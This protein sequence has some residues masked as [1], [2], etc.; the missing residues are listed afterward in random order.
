[1]KAGLVALVLSALAVACGPSA[2]PPRPA[3]AGPPPTFN[4]DVAPILYEHCAPCHRPGQGAPFVLLD[5]QDVKARADKIARATRVREMPPWLPDPIE[6][7]FVGERRLRPDQIDTIQRWFASG[8]AE[9]APA[10][11]PRRPSW[12]EGWQS[13]QPD[14]VLTPAKA[15]ILQPQQD[16]V[17][18]NLVIPVA[19]PEDRFVRAVEFSPGGAPVHHAV[20]HLDRTSASRRR[21]GSDGHPGFEGMGAP[22]R[23]SRRATSSAGRRAA[24][25]LSRRRAC[26]GCSSAARTWCSSCT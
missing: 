9:G 15:Y 19:L 16:D 25:R 23:R 8:A 18:R 17:Y 26:R 14:L 24:D 20:V 10:D 11:L 5:Y 7:G 21:D 13:G 3:A 1:M 2:P 6:P 12:T 4:K 22:G